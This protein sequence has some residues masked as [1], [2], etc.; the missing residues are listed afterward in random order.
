MPP[1]KDDRRE[2]DVFMKK[3][4]G[5]I[6]SVVVLGIASGTVT[7]IQM[8][9]AVE[10]LVTKTD[11]HEDIINTDNRSIITIEIKQQQIEQTINDLK[12]GQKENNKLILEILRAVKK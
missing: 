10:S 1:I 6:A 3:I 9:S 2:I 4:L 5:T 7:F 11:K 12:I 8:S